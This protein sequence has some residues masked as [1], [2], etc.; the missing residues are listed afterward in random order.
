MHYIQQ[1][2]HRTPIPGN[3]QHIFN[4]LHAL[5]LRKVA[6]QGPSADGHPP[7]TQSV[8]PTMGIRMGGSAPPP[9]PATNFP[10]N[11]PPGFTIPNV[12]VPGMMAQP[13]LHQLPPVAGQLHY[14][15]AVPS[16]PQPY[17]VLGPHLPPHPPIIG[18][19]HA[20]GH[21]QLGVHQAAVPATHVD[22]VGHKLPA[23]TQPVMVSPLAMQQ[24][25]V[26]TGQS[27]VPD[28]MVP[29]PV[30]PGIPPNYHQQLL[31]GMSL[32]QPLNTVE[33]R[34]DLSADQQAVDDTN[35]ISIPI[36]GKRHLIE[37]AASR[38][39][40][41]ADDP[42]T[43][44]DTSDS[45]HMM[46]AS[47]HKIQPG[48]AAASKARASSQP[49]YPSTGPARQQSGQG[50]VPVPEVS[51]LTRSESLKGWTYKE[52]APH[53]GALSPSSSP[54]QPRR[55]TIATGSEASIAAVE[56]VQCN[57]FQAKSA[58]EAQLC[59]DSDISDSFS[60]VVKD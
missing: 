29:I 56:A 38:T 17:T 1:Y 6:T 18:N 15:A 60:P 20:I 34:V 59:K 48:D 14:P 7:G 45:S 3:A 54:K 8:P 12:P 41:P 23:E 11:I 32:Q 31:M 26:G 19:P 13:L 5:Q 52:R 28:E 24:Q 46:G 9:I 49:P 36:P 35:R 42:R 55:Q 2:Y 58:S 39:P 37:S 57:L 47:P 10:M 22:G 33:Q 25:A 27:F 4:I 50:Q 43:M 30:N 21:H 51:N 16:F 53:T 44:H 40:S